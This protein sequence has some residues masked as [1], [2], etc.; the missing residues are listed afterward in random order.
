MAIFL[1]T[2]VIDLPLSVIQQGLA[3]ERSSGIRQLLPNAFAQV[4]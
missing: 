1:G 2:D 4:P 3:G